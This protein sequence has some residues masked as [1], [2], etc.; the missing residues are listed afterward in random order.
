[1]KRS[2]NAILF[3]LFV[4]G[5]W[6]LCARLGMWSPVL[7]P[8][9]VEIGRYLI[10]SVRD[11]TLIEASSV[12]LKRLL[13]GYAAGLV[14]GVPLGLLTARFKFVQDTFG[15]AALGLQTLPSVCWVPLSLIW[16]GQS[17]FAM[18]FVVIM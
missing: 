15:T 4:T 9:P 17:E 5:V 14:V 10:E 8:S 3:F 12:T 1:M 6:E 16:F 11:R 7:F 13:I 18:I 2:Q